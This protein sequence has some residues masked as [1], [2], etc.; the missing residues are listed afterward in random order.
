MLREAD[1]QFRPERQ[2][3]K[4]FDII[5]STGMGKSRVV[6]EVGFEIMSISFV[7]RRSDQAGFPLARTRYMPS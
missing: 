1:H 7:L 3:S 4:T 2:Y 6:H 5:Q